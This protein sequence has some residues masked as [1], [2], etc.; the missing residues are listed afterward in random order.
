[1]MAR[2][3]QDKLPSDKIADARH[4]RIVGGLILLS[5]LLTPLFFLAVGWLLSGVSEDSDGGDD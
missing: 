2:Q 3:S 5:L 4:W 1:M